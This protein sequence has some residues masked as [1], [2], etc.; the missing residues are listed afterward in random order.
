M[1]LYL[2]ANWNGRLRVV[3]QKPLKLVDQ[4]GSEYGFDDKIIYSGL[5]GIIHAARY[6]VSG[7]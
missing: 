5:Y 7:C 1:S 3:V 6:V 2:C 4:A